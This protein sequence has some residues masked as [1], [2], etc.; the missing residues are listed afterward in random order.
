MKTD[1]KFIDED[2]KSYLN[3]NN[4]LELGVFN[5]SELGLYS[6]LIKKHVRNLTSIDISN[7]ALQLAEKYFKEKN[8]DG[9]KLIQMN[10][11]D[12]KF[13]DN[14]FDV[15]VTASFHE[16]DPSIQFKILEEA[17]RVL[18]K[19]KKIIFIEPHEDSVT[20]ELFKV[21]D[22]NENHAQRIL[23]TK[24]C[25]RK[26]AKKYGYNINE[27]V[28][29]ISLNQFDSK[30]QLL[31]EMLNWSSDIRVPQNE[32]EE[33]QM[34]TEI[35]NTLQKFAEKDFINNQVNEIIWCWILEKKEN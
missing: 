31:N 5:G 4:C 10:A 3:C 9:I 26:F 35:Q 30:E 14:M 18:K 1:K 34:K 16:M 33:K 23:N 11:C 12:L 17:N 7:Q 25:I 15:V 13:D 27:L 2:L 21:F 20:N 22:P 6:H 28:K 19:H 8:I 24:S 32:N 29:S